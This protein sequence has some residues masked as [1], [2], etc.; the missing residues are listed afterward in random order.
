MRSEVEDERPQGGWE[1]VSAELREFI[2]ATLPDAVAAHECVHGLTQML[3]G[4]ARSYPLSA[5]G[6]LALLVPVE[7]YL[8][9]VV[10]G[11]NVQARSTG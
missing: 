4:C 1:K 3:T 7:A 6:V 10:D 8:E 2:Q 11:M 5:G 9:N